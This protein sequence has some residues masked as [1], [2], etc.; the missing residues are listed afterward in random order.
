MTEIRAWTRARDGKVSYEYSRELQRLASIEKDLNVFLTEHSP[1]LATL[2]RTKAEEVFR[3][4]VSES[5]FD[6]EAVEL[7]AFQTLLSEVNPL[8]RL[9]LTYACILVGLN[10]EDSADEVPIS[11]EAQVRTQMYPVFYLF[12]ALLRTSERDS[13]LALLKDFVDGRMKS[14]TP[15]QPDLPDPGQWWDELETPS[16]VTEGVAARFGRGKIAFRVDNCIL[17][18]VMEPLGDPE[19]AD[20]VCCYGDKSGFEALNPNLVFTRTDTLMTGPY[21]DTCMHDKRFVDDIEHPDH[22]FFQGLS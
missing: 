2:H 13:A 22:E 12:Q 14:L 7:P 19:L 20:V 9:M 1:E 21:C 11:R 16:D 17:H 10:A 5:P 18:D 4:V 6:H 8:Q 15:S 3:N